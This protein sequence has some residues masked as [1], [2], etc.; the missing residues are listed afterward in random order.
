MRMQSLK[1]NMVE[2]MRPG[3][4]TVTEWFNYW[5]ENIKGDSIRPKTHDDDKMYGRRNA[6]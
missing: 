4:M 6:P 1:M 5:I 2:S 3:D